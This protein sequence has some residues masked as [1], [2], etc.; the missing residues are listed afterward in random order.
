MTV[1]FLVEVAGAQKTPFVSGAKQVSMRKFINYLVSLTTGAFRPYGASIKVRNAAVSATNA[2]TFS[3]AATAADTVTVNGQALTATQKN[4]T[5]RITFSTIVADNSV[6]I[7]SGSATATFTAKLSPSGVSEFALGASDT[8]AATNLAAKITAH[9][10]MLNIVTATSAAAVVTVR[11]VTAG[12]AGNS[13][14]MTRV[15]SP[16]TLNDGATLVNGAAATNNA[17]DPGNTAA[18]AGEA[19]KDAVNLSTTGKVSN[20]VVATHDGAGIVTLTA[21]PGYAGNMFTLAKSG[22]NIAITGA[23]FT[24]G[25]A[26]TAFTL[27][28]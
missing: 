12:T 5:G 1:K 16:I 22:S 8:E 4:A 27:N 19:F 13:I 24:G 10:A 18:T 26:D 28:F 3:G 17:W 20:L 7:T 2:V 25:S 23:A 21:L 9:P 6:T 11:A 15:G 14:G